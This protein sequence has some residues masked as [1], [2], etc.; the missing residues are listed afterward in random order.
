MRYLQQWGEL[1]QEGYQVNTRFQLLVG[2]LLF[3]NSDVAFAEDALGIVAIRAATDALPGS[4]AAYPQSCSHG[5]CGQQQVVA[6]GVDQSGDALRAQL[7][8]VN[9]FPRN[10][11]LVDVSGGVL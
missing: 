3:G 5:E 4:R 10:G 8:F 6:D 7:N 9:Q 11:G 1:T 2:C